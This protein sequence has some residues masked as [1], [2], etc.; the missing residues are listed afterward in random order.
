MREIAAT[1]PPYPPFNL[2][3]VGNEENGEGDPFGTPH[4]LKTLE[5]E[6]GWRPELM[7][8]GERTGEQGEEIYGAICTESR[9]VLRMEITARG[10]CGHTGT[11][12][13]PRDLLESLIE[14]RSILGSSFNR[15]LTLSSLNGWETTAR[16][17]YLN[18]GEPGVYNITAGLGVLGIEVRPI[19]GDDLEALL[20]EVETLCGELDL[21]LKVEVKEA[22]VSCPPENLRLAQ[23][24]AAVETVSSEAPVIGQKKPGSSARFAPGGNQVVWGQTGIGP[25]SREERH[26]IPSIEP[27]LEVLD[28]FA[29]RVQNG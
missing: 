13:G 29:T 24:V 16:F 26:F 22:G 5:K 8:V 7:I 2:L 17:P 19:P 27:Y 6:N 25:H 11:G 1:G 4:V 3:L 12:G 23:L 28:E 14:V 20:G 9:G 10:A 18:V 15:H 21:D